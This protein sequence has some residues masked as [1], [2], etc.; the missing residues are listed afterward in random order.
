MLLVVQED[1]S[2]ATHKGIAITQL[3]QNLNLHVE[4]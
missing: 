1:N 4:V 3:L 2:C